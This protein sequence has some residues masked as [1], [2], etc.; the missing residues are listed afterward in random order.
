MHN[1]AVEFENLSKARTYL[2]FDTADLENGKEHPVIYGYISLA[3]KILTVP[4]SVSN[5]LRKELDGYNAKIHGQQISDFPC[6]L[7]GQLSKNSEFRDNP[8][9]GSD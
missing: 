8:V 9:T 4:A 6:Y 2:V 3:L 5:R 1:R 7:I